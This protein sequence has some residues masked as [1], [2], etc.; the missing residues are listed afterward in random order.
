LV[1][2]DDGPV[3]LSSQRERALLSVLAFHAG[4]VVNG[5]TL[6]DAVFGDDPPADPRHAVATLVHRVRARLG[7]EVVVTAGDGYRLNSPP[8][9]VDAWLFKRSV[10][11]G[12]D[13]AGAMRLWR[14][15][16]YADLDGWPPADAVRVQL[17]ELRRHA[18]E[19]LAA[20]ALAAGQVGPLVGQLETMVA[21]EPFR[22]RRW[23]L[24]VRALQAAGRQA[25]ALAAFARARALLVEELGIEPGPELVAAER[26]V[27]VQEPL[28]GT[29]QPAAGTVTFLFTDL[30][31]S[32]RLWQDDADTMELEVARHF[33]LLDEAIE[34][35]G[36]RVLKTMGDG[37][38]AVFSS[39][40][41]AVRAATVAQQGLLAEPWGGRCRLSVRMGVHSGDVRPRDGDYFGLA[42]SR[43][44]RLMGVAHGGQIVLS[45]AT[46]ELVRDGLPDGI[47]LVDLGEHRLRDLTRPERVFQV[48][49]AGLPAKFPPLRSLDAYP[50]NLPS[51][52]STFVGRTVEL[53]AVERAL[54]SGRLVTVTGV[55]GVGKT[56]LALHVAAHVLP[57]FRDG[58]WFCELAAVGRP[59]DVVEVVAAAL[60]MPLRSGAAT[61][62][63]LVEFLKTRHA[64]LVLDNCEHLLDGVG[65]VVEAVLRSCPGV[66][67]LATSREG[68]GLEGERVWPLRSLGL[69]EPGADVSVV[70]ASAAVELFVDRAAA[71]RP[72]F[73]LDRS[74][75]AA[76]E[77]ICRRLDGIPLAI[78]LAAARVVAFAPDQI[79][80]L[81]DERFRLLTGGRRTAVE[82]HQTLRATVDWSYVL[83]SERER[84]LFG[85]LGV[86]VGGFDAAAA[87]AVAQGDGLEAWDVLDALSQL[88]AKSMVVADD[89]A[90]GDTR[91]WLLETLRQYALERLAE[92]GPVDSWR[93]RH[94]Q[95]YTEF[96]KTVG[97]ALIGADELAWRTRLHEELD[98]L[99]AAVTW[100]LDDDDDQL[101]VTIIAWL[102]RA[103]G[104]EAASGLAAWA[105]AAVERARQAPAGIRMAVLCAAALGVFVSATDM[106]R[107]HALALEAFADGIPDDCPRLELCYFILS[108]T[109]WGVGQIDE[110][111]EVLTQGQGVLEAKGAPAAAIATIQNGL[112]FV[113]GI[114][115]DPERARREAREN[116]RLA[117]AAA[118]PSLMAV[119]FSHL[120]SMTWT[121]EPDAALAM[122]EESI[123]LTE[124]GASGVGYGYA[125]SLR[126]Q[127]RARAGLPGP[128]LA[129]LRHAVGYSRDK[130]DWVMIATV[131]DRG[132]MVLTEL[133]QLE[134]AAVAGIA[135]TTGA[136]TD[137]SILPGPERPERHRT[138]EQLRADLGE[139]QFTA[140]STSSVGMS[141]P[142][143]IE[144]LLS[145]L[146][147]IIARVE[148][149]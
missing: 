2:T 32:T 37:V 121:D 38:F 58:V 106:E 138:L 34:R 132:M 114:G 64:L 61:V 126:A 69:P 6:A 59:E 49:A 83:L 45:L 62:E 43:A 56:R 113:Y 72:D 117:R 70:A 21:D 90:P 127:L 30:E 123:R 54:S 97:P 95:H 125:L 104:Q 140:L 17:E 145:D 79:A 20:R 105:Q 146:D 55:G 75:A 136:L 76:V 77:Q 94:A 18:E 119:A 47:G 135:V 36:G 60:R 100:S 110:V 42:L 51:E 73:A 1:T 57:E 129:D 82:R 16:P 148:A 48:T 111:V 85:R 66:W 14:G 103:V 19:E 27:L 23:A 87:V 29:G 137:L 80:G 74:N 50:T 84:V 142:D 65:G 71:A 108:L 25:D 93:R 12:D 122:I 22:E 52:L 112:A 53:A 139:E 115:D 3:V 141:R 116:V 13:L 8:E 15:R 39:A 120:A 78:E 9:R 109:H 41:A 98:N 144:Y 133:G 91:Y 68:L 44:A 149:G 107:A 31:G 63:P 92:K 131:V 24:L 99:R 46:E 4:R 96:A 86:F 118:N 128:A 10:E 134:V 33:E 88:V 40:V 101:G 26:A 35:V 67:I 147:R 89:R 5:D 11:A 124:A 143:L 81:L 28:A 7:A 102:L 130:G